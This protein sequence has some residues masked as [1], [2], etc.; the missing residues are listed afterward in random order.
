MAGKIKSMK[1][2]KDPIGNQTRN[3]QDCSAVPQPTALLHTLYHSLLGQKLHDSNNMY[4]Q[5]T[6]HRIWYPVTKNSYFINL[7]LSSNQ[8]L[9]PDSKKISNSALQNLIH[10]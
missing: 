3:L 9:L 2:I 4:V 7:Y 6:Q 8:T 1:N 10:T 5:I